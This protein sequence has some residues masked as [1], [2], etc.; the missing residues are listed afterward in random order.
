M[1]H[2]QGG[3]N[4]Q[5]SQKSSPEFNYNLKGKNGGGGGGLFFQNRMQGPN[6]Y[7]FGSEGGGIYNSNNNNYMSIKEP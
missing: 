5:S 3:Q 2:N 4:I 1:I 7:R 6:A